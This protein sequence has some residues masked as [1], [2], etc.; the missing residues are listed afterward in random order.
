[1]NI[2]TTIHYTF[3]VVTVRTLILFTTVITVCDGEDTVG[4]CVHYNSGNST[5]SVD[6]P[7]TDSTV[8]TALY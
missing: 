8:D 7:A 5:F 2:A 1:M 6:A 4:M 3:G